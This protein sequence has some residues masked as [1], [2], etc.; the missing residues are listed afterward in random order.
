ME[1]ELYIP[2]RY[3]GAKCHIRLYSVNTMTE[4]EGVL[5]KRLV[6]SFSTGIRLLGRK[7]FANYEGMCLGPRLEDGRQTILLIAD[8]QNRAGNALYHLKDYIRVI[9]VKP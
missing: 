5:P 9:T 8:S 3:N 2:R 1:R 4:A 6:H 7:N